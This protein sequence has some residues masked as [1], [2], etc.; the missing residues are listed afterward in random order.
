MWATGA[1]R[2]AFA[3][4]EVAFERNPVTNGD[5][6]DPLAHTD[7]SSRALVSEDDREVETEGLGRRGPVVEL[8]VCTAKRRRCHLDQNLAG[9]SGGFGPV[10]A[11][12]DAALVSGL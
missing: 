4:D 2:V 11:E 5:G 7:Y 8:A 3:A 1:A 10:L 12:L 9:G 6:F